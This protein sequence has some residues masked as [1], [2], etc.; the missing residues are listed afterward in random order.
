[1]IQI[2]KQKGCLKNGLFVFCLVFCLLAAG[3]KNA[4]DNNALLI[5]KDW[6]IGDTYFSRAAGAVSGYNPYKLARFSPDHK[7]IIWGDGKFSAGKWSW[8]NDTTIALKP[9]Y[10]ELERLES[11]WNIV[12]LNEKRL[13]VSVY[14]MLDNGPGQI[15]MELTFLGR[16]SKSDKD[17]YSLSAN[18]WRRK[19]PIAETDAEIKRR[20]NDY[21]RFLEATYKYAVDNEA[22]SMDYN[23]FPQPLRMQY[24]NGVRMAYNNE[25]DDWNACFYD[26][27]QAIKGYQLVG[28]SLADT[29]MQSADNLAERNLDLVKQMII[30]LEQIK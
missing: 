19:P 24:A 29:K 17:P 6:N 16:K 4:K 28:M 21:L 25:L 8:K 30:N 22:T 9:V 20:V 2:F 5:S 3:C 15:E 1:M 27:A 23:A 14:R 10:G 12:F 26:S 13:K 11:Y 7:F 18:L